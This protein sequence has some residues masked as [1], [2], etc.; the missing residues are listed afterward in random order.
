MAP[1]SKVLLQEDVMDNP[2]NHMAAS[3]DLMMMGF[4]GKQRTLETWEKVV[5]EAGLKIASISR[6]KGPW[7]SL[8][9]IECVKKES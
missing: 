8:C 1:D 9:V 5:G 7:R 3:L 4:G 6:G 2:P